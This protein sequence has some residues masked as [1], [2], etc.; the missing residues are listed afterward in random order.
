METVYLHFIPRRTQLKG[1]AK[2]LQAY[3]QLCDRLIQY[4]EFCL[5]VIRIKKIKRFFS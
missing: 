5:K 4:A 2:K 3:R 1:C